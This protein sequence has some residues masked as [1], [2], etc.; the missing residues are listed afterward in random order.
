MR[1]LS[2]TQGVTKVQT[3]IAAALGMPYHRVSVSTKRLGGGFGGKETRAAPLGG[4][5]AIAAHKLQRPVRLVL[6]RD[7]DML[8]SGQVRTSSSQGSGHGGHPHTCPPQCPLTTHMHPHA[9]HMCHLLHYTAAHRLPPSCHP[10]ATSMPPLT[11]RSFP[12]YFLDIPAPLSNP[13]ATSTCSLCQRHAVV[14]QY[15]VAFQSDSTIVGFQATAYANAGYSHD[16]SAAVMCRVLFSITNAYRFGAVDIK[17][18]LCKTNV[19]SHTAFRGFGST[20]VSRVGA[21]PVAPSEHTLRLPCVVGT[22][23]KQCCCAC[24]TYH[25]RRTSTAP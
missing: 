21:V 25:Q 12:C 9:I 15:R 8:V 23:R 1:V 4:V 14:S 20:Q 17:G 11:P 2:S 13:L 16:L 18:R 19:T 24:H 3:T 6:D 7:V 22:A 10:Y 5:A